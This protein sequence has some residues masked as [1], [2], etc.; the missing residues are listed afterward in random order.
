[1]GFAGREGYKRV[2]IDVAG[3]DNETHV[4]TLKHPV[5]LTIL[6]D[7]IPKSQTN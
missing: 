2:N 3:Y 1:M 4:A 7:L 6:V 5:T